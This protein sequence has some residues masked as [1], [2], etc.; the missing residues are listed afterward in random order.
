MDQSSAGFLSPGIF[1]ATT[2]KWRLIV[3]LLT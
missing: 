2:S 1:S 3:S